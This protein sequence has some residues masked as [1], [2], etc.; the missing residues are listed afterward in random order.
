MHKTL[1][2]TSA[3]VLGLL[4]IAGLAVGSDERGGW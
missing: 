2:T 3:G 4:A 1:W